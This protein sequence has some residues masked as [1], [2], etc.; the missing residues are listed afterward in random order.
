M[1]TRDESGSDT[2]DAPV[3]A[4]K[5]P[6]AAV[7]TTFMTQVVSDP[8]GVGLRI[9]SG[10]P[11]KQFASRAHEPAAPPQLPSPVHAGSALLLMQCLPGPAPFVQFAGPVPALPERVPG[12]LMSSNDWAPSG[13]S[14]PATTVALPPP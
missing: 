10:G 9:G 11:K 5:V 12:P 1:Y 14:P 8:N 13:I 3:V 2:D 4:S 6:L 7:W